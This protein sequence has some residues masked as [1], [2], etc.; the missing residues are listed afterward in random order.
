VAAHINRITLKTRAG[1]LVTIEASQPT[2]SYARATPGVP[3]QVCSRETAAGVYIATAILP[4]AA[5]PGMW[6][7]DR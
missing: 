3:P 2:R 7:A 1:Q 6:G 5:D 4:A